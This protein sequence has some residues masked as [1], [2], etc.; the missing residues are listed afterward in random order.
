MN[1]DTLVNA[2]T[3]TS[4][5]AHRHS[6]RSTGG[7][8]PAVSSQGT[9]KSPTSGTP[10][11]DFAP[12]RQAP[13]RGYSSLRNASAAFR[14]MSLASV[15]PIVTRRP[16]PANGRTTTPAFSQAAAKSMVRSPSRSQTK[17]AWV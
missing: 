17:F 10:E 6:G 3:F 13:P 2:F 12:R 1:W 4:I 5:M 7:P 15:S 16:S 14:K 11:G 9:A 8:L